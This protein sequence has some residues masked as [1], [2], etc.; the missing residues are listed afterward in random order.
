MAFTPSAIESWRKPV[1][2]VNTSMRL[3]SVDCRGRAWVPQAH[4]SDSNTVS[5]SR[6]I[7]S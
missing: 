1:V 7:K 4:A 3:V 2:F 6:R 5:E